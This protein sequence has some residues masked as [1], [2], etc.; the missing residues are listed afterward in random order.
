MAIR[1]VSALNYWDCI[2]GDLNSVLGVFPQGPS[3]LS[4]ST[5]GFHNFIRQLRA[6][7]DGHDDRSSGLL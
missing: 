4:G 5:W 2:I 6:V 1:V 3:S 7:R